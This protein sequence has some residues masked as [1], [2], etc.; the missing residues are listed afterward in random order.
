LLTLSSHLT[1][2]GGG[3]SS[4]NR[5]SKIT[6][7]NEGLKEERMRKLQEK[8]D[9]EAGIAK[10]PVVQP[11]PRSEKRMDVVPQT[12]ARAVVV[13]QAVQEKKKTTTTTGPNPDH[14]GIHPSRMARVNY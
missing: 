14:A 9:L 4:E 5:K 6:A 1:S 3:G 10:V 8:K 13:P 2:A 11:L 12:K 7:K